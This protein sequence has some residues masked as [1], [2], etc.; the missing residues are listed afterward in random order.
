MLTNTYALNTL[1]YQWQF[2]DLDITNATTSTYSIATAHQATD[3]GNYRCVVTDA[4]GSQRTASDEVYLS[5]NPI[6]APVIDTAPVGAI[7]NPGGEVTFTITAH[8]D[9]PLYYSWRLYETNVAF[10]GTDNTF[11]ITGLTANNSGPYTCVVTNHAGAATS[12]PVG[13]NVRPFSVS[14][15]RS[16]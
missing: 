12:A 6:Q 8:G 14:A 3:Q 7:I 5:V 11:T 13:M 2:N 16:R 1:K 10:T 15:E 4:Y 9:L